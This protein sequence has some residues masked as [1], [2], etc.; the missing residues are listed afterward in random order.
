MRKRKLKKGLSKKLRFEKFKHRSLVDV[1]LFFIL[2]FVISALVVILRADLSQTVSPL[3]KEIAFV[4]LVFLSLSVLI[5]YYEYHA[6]SKSEGIVRRGPEEMVVALTFDDGPSPEYTNLV[7]DVLKKHNVKATFFLVG[8]HIKKYPEVAR[9]IVLEGHEVGNHTFSHRDL[10]PSS[11]K[12][13]EFEVFETQKLIKEVLGVET[14]LF[15]PPRGIFSEA[16]RK[17]IV[18]RG[19]ILVLWSVS[20]VDWAKTPPSIIAKRIIRF[21]H[22][23]AIIL[24]HDSGA[25][26]RSEGHSRLNTVKALEIIIPALKERGYRFVTVS[27]LIKLSGIKEVEAAAEEAVAKA[28]R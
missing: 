24:L 17:F 23:G 11:R 22:P 27:E 7:L 16:V 25:L 19:L 28:Y 10:V 26:I 2:M 13:L 3:L 20:G 4:S 12:R 21:T 5:T 6:F 1:A 15:R 14:N 8:K 9:R 18:S